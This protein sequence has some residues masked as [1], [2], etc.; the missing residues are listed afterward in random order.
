MID[1]VLGDAGGG[2]LHV[3]HLIAAVQI[4]PADSDGGGPRDLDGAAGDVPTAFGDAMDD[5]LNVPQALA[6]LHETVRAG[7]SALADGVDAAAPARAVRAMTDVLGLSALM[8]LG[9]LELF[10]ILALFTRGLWRA[11]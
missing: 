5:D 2:T 4:I 3:A 1:L 7:N 10:T 9:R 8:L 6:V 11:R